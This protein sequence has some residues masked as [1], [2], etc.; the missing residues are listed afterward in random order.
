MTVAEA[1]STWGFAFLGDMGGVPCAGHAFGAQSG[2]DFATN[3]VLRVIEAFPPLLA[4][5]PPGLSA[6]RRTQQTFPLPENGWRTVYCTVYRLAARRCL[7]TRTV[8]QP[9]DDDA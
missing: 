9:K 6:A 8:P 1:L 2:G 3:H 5:S 4:G 7:N